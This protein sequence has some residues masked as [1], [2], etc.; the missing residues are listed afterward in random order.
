MVVSVIL[1]AKPEES[2]SE[3]LRPLCGLRM[4]V[5]CFQKL[6]PEFS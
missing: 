6:T 3:I 5:G 2:K 4:T 1:R